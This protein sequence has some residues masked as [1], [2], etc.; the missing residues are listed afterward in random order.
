MTNSLDIGPAPD[1]SIIMST[2]NERRWIPETVEAIL[3]QTHANIELL[4]IDDASTDGSSE[5]LASYTDPRLT[6]IRHEERNGW[7][8]NM[9]KLA[10]LARGRLLKAHCPDDIMRPNCVKT[11][12]ELYER[13]PEVGFLFCDFDWI[14]ERGCLVEG[15][16]RPDY[17]SVIPKEQADDI[18]L[19]DGCFANTSCLFVPRD[20]WHSVGGMRSVVEPNPERWP[21]VEDFEIMIRLQEWYD[22]GYVPEPHVGVRTHPQQVQG[23]VSVR[24]L[25]IKADLEVIRILWSRLDAKQPGKRAEIKDKV[26]RRVTRDYFNRGVKLLLAGHWRP[27]LSVMSIVNDLVA[28]PLL[29]PTWIRTIVAPAIARRIRRQGQRL[30]RLFRNP[31]LALPK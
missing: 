28:L 12:L 8:N 20:K 19:V 29:I 10:T 2:F 15:R 26:L 14:D 25:L 27:A 31:P 3:A 23:N 17:P 11:A 6:V 16:E 5:L 7:L 4:V 9:N 22:V 13:H 30:S 18:A 24:P 21:T 1:V